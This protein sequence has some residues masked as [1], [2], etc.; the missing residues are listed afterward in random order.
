MASQSSPPSSSRVIS[1]ERVLRF[2]YEFLDENG[3]Q[4]ALRALQAE[5]KV[6]YNTIHVKLDDTDSS[7]SVVRASLSAKRFGAKGFPA[8][9][10]RNLE[11]AVM[12][13]SW[14]E[15]LHVYVDGLLLPEEIK[16]TLYE[17]ILEEIVELHG[18]AP[19]ARSLLLNAPIFQLMKTDAPA[20]YI[21]LEKM[22]E[23]G[24]RTMS[25]GT[26]SNAATRHVT[27]EMLQKRTGLLQHLKTAI[28]FTS[29]APV[30][31]LAAALARAA[32]A[33]IDGVDCSARTAPSVST[34]SPQSGE[35]TSSAEATTVVMRS[36]KR[37][38]EP[39][40][41]GDS[42]WADTFL[43]YPL[44]APKEIR[45]RLL[46][47]GERAACCCAPLPS[48]NE[49]LLM[50]GCADGVIEFVSVATG[51]RIGSPL[52]H[53]DGV[54]C[55]APDSEDGAGPAPGWIA[56]GYRDGW[57]KVYNVSSRKLVRR[58]EKVHSMG[59]TAVFFSGP[60][61]AASLSGHHSFIVTGSFDGSVKVLDIAAGAVVRT[62]ANSHASAFVHALLPLET[63]GT[64]ADALRYCFLS[65]G[66]DG[67][68]SLWRL[69]SDWE[70][71]AEASGTV[72]LQRVQGAILLGQVHHEL[73]DAVPTQLYALP[74][75]EDTTHGAIAAGASAG[76]PT[77]TTQDALVLT[78]AG[79]ACVMRITVKDEGSRYFCASCQAL[80][81]IVTAHPL[82]SAFPRVHT[83]V[84]M[85][86]PLL[87]LY[88]A[89]SEG[90]VSLY[91]IE[92]RW[93]KE[94]EWARLGGC[95]R[96]ISAA[97]QSAAVIVEA[98]KPVK[99]L[100]LTCMWPPT[101]HQPS[102]VV[103]YSASLPAIYSMH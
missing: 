43:Q 7:C 33:H 10:E 30:G 65:S 61:N 51:E 36:R 67:T 20:R 9:T 53:S 77:A 41:P 42:A 91:N 70:E 74:H 49:E 22:I 97:E 25:E 84:S 58:F 79:K 3:Y 83:V 56:V 57:V 69:E 99:D 29:E 68:L 75:V 101:Q 27:P 62:V 8:A 96:V 82:R 59:I 76:V 6:P 16:A 34:E 100:Q 78:R 44:A 71:G 64:V 54:L 80:C 85:S 18:L 45:R 37:S 4:Q 92:M 60:R 89:D 46:Y 63:R 93:Y 31:R 90:T 12:E 66:N 95:M 1:H 15:V 88:A 39:A 86:V 24:Q 13:G 2:V 102:S 17:V 103:A 72:E 23:R 87:T 38:R 19:A 98:G 48:E 52:R 94:E 32:A 5:S 11:R 14:A 21:R 47:S 35:P 26:V 28:R 73:R 55:M 40:L 50:V 81:I